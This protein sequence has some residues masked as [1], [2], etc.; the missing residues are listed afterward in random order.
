M[1]IDLSCS[2]YIANLTFI[3]LSYSD[4]K[5]AS[6]VPRCWPPRPVKDCIAAYGAVALLSN[7]VRL[8]LGQVIVITII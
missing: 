8:T 6:I 1:S 7:L 3:H 5:D 2:D 4:D